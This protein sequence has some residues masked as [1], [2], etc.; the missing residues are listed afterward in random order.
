MQCLSPITLVAKTPKQLLVAQRQGR[1]RTYDVPCGKC[2]ACLQ[3][4]RQDW[5]VR[6]KSEMRVSDSAFFVT[7]TYDD[8]NLPADGMLSVRDPQLFLKRLRQHPEVHGI[9]FR[10]FLVGEYGSTTFRPHYHAIIFNLPV[11]DS[12]HVHLRQIIEQVW[13]K[14]GV[15]LVPASPATIAYTCKYVLTTQEI[16]KKLELRTIPLMSSRRPAIGSCFL[17]TQTARKLQH[18]T[19][20]YIK[21]DG[22]TFS[23]PRYYV[24]KLF[25]DEQKRQLSNER[26]EFAKIK[27]LSPREEE[28]IYYQRQQQLKK[29]SKQKL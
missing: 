14:G 4:R 12:Q 6:L 23:L 5:I 17:D 10:Y 8:L 11:F 20:G 28:Q 29:L 3:K 25:T 9:N 27:E 1:L 16:A 13:R 22:V 26:K 18:D 24:D 21:S 19:Q 15:H 2:L 7:L